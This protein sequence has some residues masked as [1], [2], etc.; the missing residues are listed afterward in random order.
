VSITDIVPD[1]NGQ[2]EKLRDN[3]WTCYLSGAKIASISNSSTAEG[4][5]QTILRNLWIGHFNK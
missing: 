1:I 4:V 2:A 3:R 5:D